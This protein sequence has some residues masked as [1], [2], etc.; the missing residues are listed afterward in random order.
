MYHTRL[1]PGISYGGEEDGMIDVSTIT[2]TSNDIPNV[3]A[4][5]QKFNIQPVPNFEAY[6]YTKNGTQ[7]LIADLTLKQH[8]VAYILFCIIYHQLHYQD[9]LEANFATGMPPNY[10]NDSDTEDD[11]I[12]LTY[13]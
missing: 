10:N 11:D 3:Y 7:T 12:I 9:P 13:Y 2:W 4:N 8:P 6:E 5:L 1:P